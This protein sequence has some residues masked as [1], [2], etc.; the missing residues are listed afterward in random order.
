MYLTHAL[1][2]LL[3]PVAVQDTL[4]PATHYQGGSIL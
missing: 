4:K 3:Q 1:F 2:A